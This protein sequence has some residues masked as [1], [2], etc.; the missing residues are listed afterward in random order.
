MW[1]NMTVACKSG[2][3]NRVKMFWGPCHVQEKWSKVSGEVKFNILNFLK[4]EMHV[5]IYRVI[6]KMNN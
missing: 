3:T 6:S 2:E 5:V 4:S 1:Q